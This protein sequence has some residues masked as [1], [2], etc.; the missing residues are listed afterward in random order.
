[1]S[2]KTYMYGVNYTSYVCIECECGMPQVMCGEDVAN[3]FKYC[4]FCGREI[5]A[6][7]ESKTDAEVIEG[8]KNAD[9]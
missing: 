5:T 3:H 9:S 6:F 1:M 7:Y 8:E 4:P 2:G